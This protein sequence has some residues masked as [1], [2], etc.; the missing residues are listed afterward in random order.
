[1]SFGPTQHFCIA[2]LKEQSSEDSDGGLAT[3][4]EQ[5]SASGTQ[6]AEEKMIRCQMMEA[7]F[8]PSEPEVADFNGNS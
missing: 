7:F 6:N 1:M 4:P 3:L 8:D 5:H 2:K